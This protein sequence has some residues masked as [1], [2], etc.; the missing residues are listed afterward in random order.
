M[1]ILVKVFF[2]LSLMGM[3]LASLFGSSLLQIKMSHH[4]KLKSEKWMEDEKNLTQGEEVF[5]KTKDC[6]LANCTL[7]EFVPDEY[8]EYE[9]TG[10]SYYKIQRGLTSTFAIREENPQQ[11]KASMLDFMGFDYTQ[12]GYPV[13]GIDPHLFGFRAYTLE[14]TSEANRLLV[15]Q[16]LGGKT[17]L[18]YLID[19]KTSLSVP[20]LWHDK[21]IIEKLTEKKLAVYEALTGK[22]LIE[23]NVKK[24]LLNHHYPEC[25][26]R[27]V[28]L[29]REPREEKRKILLLK[30]REVWSAEVELDKNL[31]GR[32]TEESTL[33]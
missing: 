12:F 23:V 7:I 14:K 19:E 8:I 28:V 17:K 5:E 9:R 21:L 10:V 25:N 31:L 26:S 11:I 4:F 2:Y 13:I 22:K 29:I 1:G 30:D 6:H 15:Y 27:P 24:E 20:K 3:M 32:R 16:I 18:L 33:Q